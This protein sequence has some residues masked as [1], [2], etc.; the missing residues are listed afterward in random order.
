MAGGST[1]LFY[2]C[3]SQTLR[4]STLDWAKLSLHPQNS[5]STRTMLQ[6]R[7]NAALDFREGNKKKKEE[8]SRK[9]RRRNIRSDVKVEERRRRVRE[10]SRKVYNHMDIGLF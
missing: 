5:A 4:S 2:C 8:K 3:P 1:L 7:A 10:N 6:I 9:R